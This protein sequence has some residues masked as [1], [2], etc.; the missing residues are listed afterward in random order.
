MPV[1]SED[2]SDFQSES[3]GEFAVAEQA[4]QSLGFDLSPAGVRQFVSDATSDVLVAGGSVVG[5]E[6]EAESCTDVATTGGLV[7]GTIAAAVGTAFLGP[8]AG[9]ALGAL[10]AATGAAQSGAICTAGK[11]VGGKR[12]KDQAAEE[13]VFQSETG[14]NTFPLPAVVWDEVI[15]PLLVPSSG[16]AVGR[17][18]TS[19]AIRPDVAVAM[20]VEL[21]RLQARQQ[22]RQAATSSSALLLAGLAGLAAYKYL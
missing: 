17:P 10:G 15:A 20:P 7:G 14:A 19:G 5:L 11:A 9:L 21:E 1:V 16:P 12:N 13:G 4:G 2:R 6:E 18:G 3:S 22:E 8:F